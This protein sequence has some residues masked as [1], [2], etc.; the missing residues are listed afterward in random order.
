MLAAS[1]LL[2]F[3]VIDEGSKFHRYIGY[4]ACALIAVRL[5]WAVFSSDEHARLKYFF[6]SYTSLKNYVLALI[7]KQEPRYLSHNPLA[8]LMMT[9]MCLLVLLLGLSGWMSRWDMFWGEDWVEEWHE[10]M[11]NLLMAATLLH[12]TAAIVESYRHK[13]NLIASMI[14]GYKSK[15]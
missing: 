7:K 9:F 5:L 13:E 15:N 11:S 3:F 12:V 1:V 10:I 6:P 14:H 2:N 8:G 4:F